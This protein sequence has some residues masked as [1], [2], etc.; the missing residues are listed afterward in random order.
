MLKKKFL[1]FVLFVLLIFALLTYQSIKGER[2]V[3]DF[4]L[5]PLK[6]LEQGGSF[7]MNIFRHL[8]FVGENDGERSL[9]DRL[10]HCEKERTLYK[11][12]AYENER[13]RELLQLKSERAD[14]VAAAEVFARDPTNWFQVLWINRGLNSGI[15]RDMVA[16]TP[17]GLVGRVHRVFG[18]KSDL[19]LIT[20]VN[21]S[22]AVRLET[23]RIEGILEG[24]GDNKCILK[25]V[26]KDFEVAAGESVIT[27][28]L[29]G[30]FPEGLLVGHVSSVDKEGGEVFQMIDVIP[31]Q[32][33]NAVE[34]VVILKR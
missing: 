29:D 32:N 10:K 1:L 20:D 22:V 7:L 14:T 17:L 5:Y 23:S 3:S 19:I 2:R 15:A 18:E 25:Y 13:L 16:V 6:A 28:G 26:S 21:S 12:A 34:E 11:E 9:L 33:L 31:S 24:S 8:P 30:V 27:S 4:T